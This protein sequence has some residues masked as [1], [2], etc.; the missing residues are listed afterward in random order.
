M[1]HRWG[2]RQS[3]D[4]M[5]RFAAGPSAVGRG[6]VGTAR[7]VNVS[8]S[9]AFLETSAGLRV[10]SLLYLEPL[11]AQR[12]AVP[13]QIAASV[14]RRTESG[15]GVEWAFSG[16]QHFNVSALLA[17]LAG[18]AFPEP[19]GRYAPSLAGM[20]RRGM[21]A[22]ATAAASMTYQAGARIEPPAR[23]L[24]QFKMAGANPPKIVKG[25]L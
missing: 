21:A 16:E 19:A 8:V 14:I 15:A 20:P 22:N 10:L 17:V 6:A 24:N 13:A 2:F 4:L 18:H 12:G 3:T 7:I 23:L 1:E 25:P 11:T 5:V 9:G